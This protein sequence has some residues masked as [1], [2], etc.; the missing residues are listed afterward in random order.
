MSIDTNY[1]PTIGLEIH[2]EL[3]TNSKLF[4]GCKNDPF[5]KEPNIYTCPVCLGLPGA[6]PVINKQAVIDTIKI[7]KALGGTIAPITKWDR[8]HYFYPDLPK[9]YQIS[10]YDAPLVSGGH[11]ELKVENEKLKVKITR[12]HLEEDTGKLVHESGS[13]TSLVDLNR[14]GVPLVELVT[15]PDIHDAKTAS[16]FA[17]EYQLII[18][19]LEVSDASMEKGEMRVEVNISLKRIQNVN[20]KMQNH[21]SKL[22]IEETDNQL[23]TKVEIKNLNSFKSVEKAIEYEIKRQTE[24]L[25]KDEKI[26]QETRGWSDGRG[27]TVSQ[28]TKETSADYRYFPEPDLPPIDT[29]LLSIPELPL[30]PYQI[31]E[32]L[33]EEGVRVKDIEIILRNR[34][35]FQKIEDL[36]FKILESNLELKIS[37]IAT[38][39]VHNPKLKEKSVDELI[40]IAELSPHQR[41]LALSG[42]MHD[43]L[44][45]EDEIKSIIEKILQK[46]T[47]AVVDYKAGK[48]AVYGF[49]VGQVMRECQGKADPQIVNRLLKNML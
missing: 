35:L 47:Q 25:E 5:C 12:I 27:T 34:E 17:K 3:K 2:A 29:G 1:I 40:K 22:R 20:L 41:K 33:S 32:N 23:G 14:A 8:K 6:L 45:S 44:I 7:G 26:V 4:C 42:K 19:T 11:I 28:R 31:R 30:L 21:N 18:R 15:E 37:E 36:R 43:Q 48:E 9:G 10:Q 46:E 13:D 16:E 49:L 39:L 38:M 24:L